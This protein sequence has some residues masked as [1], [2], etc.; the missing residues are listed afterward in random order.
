LTVGISFK[1]KLWRITDI[2]YFQIM[3]VINICSVRF[4]CFSHSTNATLHLFLFWIFVMLFLIYL[5][6][7]QS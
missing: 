5:S 6:D 3:F 2:H 1:K 4:W 7:I